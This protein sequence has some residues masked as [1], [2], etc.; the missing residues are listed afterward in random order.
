MS[1]CRLLWPAALLSVMQPSS[2]FLYLSKVY[3]NKH[4]H[5]ICWWMDNTRGVSWFFPGFCVLLLFEQCHSC[6]NLSWDHESYRLP[7][8]LSV[9]KG[10]CRWGLTKHI[11][12]QAYSKMFVRK[13]ARSISKENMVWEWTGLQRRSFNVV[14]NDKP[15]G[16]AID[17]SWFDIA[18]TIPI[19]PCTARRRYGNSKNYSMS[20]NVIMVSEQKIERGT[21]QRVKEWETWGTIC[22]FALFTV[23]TQ[24]SPSTKKF[25]HRS[26]SE[27]GTSK[28]LLFNKGWSLW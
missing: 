16:A 27:L 19:A 18:A 5:N 4:S 22:I 1:T 21:S 25:S 12:V 28:L 3:T 26:V 7:K 14:V 17:P 13:R 24:R 11:L 8:L 6:F 9:K 15:G 10:S 23:A 2:I 20:T